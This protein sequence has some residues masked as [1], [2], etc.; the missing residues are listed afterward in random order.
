MQNCQIVTVRK[1]V[2]IFENYAIGVVIC[3]VSKRIVYLNH[4]VRLRGLIVSYKPKSKSTINYKY[5]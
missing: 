1:K 4:Y 2:L 5:L 3:F